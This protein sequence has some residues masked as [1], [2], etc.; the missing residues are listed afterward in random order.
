MKTLYFASS[1]FVNIL[2]S[3]VVDLIILKIKDIENENR[4]DE[5]IAKLLKIKNIKNKNFI[6]ENIAKLLKIKNIENESRINENI[7]KLSN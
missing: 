7:A 3:I 1:Q 6:N 4:I 2:N 5:N